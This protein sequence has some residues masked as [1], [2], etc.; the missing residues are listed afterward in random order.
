MTETSKRMI[1]AS[2]IVAALVA[3][4]AIVDLVA[5]IPFSGEFMVMDIC[6]LIGSAITFYMCYDAWKDLR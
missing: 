1:I 6:F 4:A 3:A 5:G 2:A